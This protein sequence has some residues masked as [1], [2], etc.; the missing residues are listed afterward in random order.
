MERFPKFSYVKLF[1]HTSNLM[2]VVN[3]LSKGTMHGG[4]PP[5][6]TYKIYYTA[7]SHAK[8]TT[9]NRIPRHT[10]KTIFVNF[11]CRSFLDS[12]IKLVPLLRPF[13]IIRLNGKRNA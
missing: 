2:T 8:I 13:D 3:F 10:A 12:R 11:L 7:V 5:G 9:N 4:G 6:I 1:S